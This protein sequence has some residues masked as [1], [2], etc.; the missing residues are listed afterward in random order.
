MMTVG[1]VSTTGVKDYGVGG[2]GSHRKDVV[3]RALLP[4]LP[5]GSD[6]NLTGF[7]V[8]I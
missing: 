4:R 1:R 8:S 3:D 6:T 5:P 7:I 2:E